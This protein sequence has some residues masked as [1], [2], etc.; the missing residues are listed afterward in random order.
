MSLHRL[1]LKE[2]HP[3]MVIDRDITMLTN[4]II[5]ISRLPYSSWKNQDRIR[6]L[7]KQ[8]E[9][10]ESVLAAYERDRKKL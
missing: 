10:L 5:R 9:Y 4:E 1:I 3:T 8:I 6:S 7:D 2:D